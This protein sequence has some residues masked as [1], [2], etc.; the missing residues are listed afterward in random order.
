MCLI[1]LGDVAGVL[2]IYDLTYGRISA[3]ECCLPLVIAVGVG[4]G[5]SDGII[6]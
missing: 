2:G 6:Q 1:I 4:R 3:A 5:R